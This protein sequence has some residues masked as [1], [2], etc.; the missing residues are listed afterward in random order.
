MVLLLFPPC[1]HTLSLSSPAAA[2]ANLGYGRCF[3]SSRSFFL[4]RG[5]REVRGRCLSSEEEEEGEEDKGE[6]EAVSDNEETYPPL[7]PLPTCGCMRRGGIC[8]WLPWEKLFSSDTGECNEHLPGAI[9][10]YERYS[11]FCLFNTWA[12][13]NDSISRYMGRGEVEMRFMLALKASSPPPY[14]LHLFLSFPPECCF[15]FFL[16]LPSVRGGIKAL[17]YESELSEDRRRERRGKGGEGKVRKEQREG[18]VDDATRGKKR[19]PTE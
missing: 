16:L 12:K 4:R 18:V 10:S 15:F 13:N 8:S 5:G 14:F 7:P 17:K 3:S 6:M 9:H 1:T 2:P 11:I 19:W